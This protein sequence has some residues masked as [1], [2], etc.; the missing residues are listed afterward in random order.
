MAIGIGEVPAWVRDVLSLGRATALKKGDNGVRPLVCH[1]PVRRLLTRAL[2]FAS[3]ESIQSYLGPNQFAVG[4]Q[5]GCPAMACSVKKL[6][7]R[8]KDLI[9][10]KLDLV[11]A[12]NTQCREVALQNLAVPSPALASF[13]KQF[14]GTESQYFY[15]SLIH[16]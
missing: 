5:G 2:V 11:N 12:Y 14:Y 4:V 3:G 7:H 10:F 1:E 9:F 6:A 15:L 13:L 16:I 8:H